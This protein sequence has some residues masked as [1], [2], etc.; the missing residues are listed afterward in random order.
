MQPTGVLDTAKATNPLKDLLKFGQSVWLDYIRRDLISSG[1][2][3]RLIQEDGLRGMTSNPA[4][5]EKAISGSTD[6]ADILDQLKDRS[7]LD[8]KARYEAIAIRDIQDAA[9][10]LRPVYDESSRRDG[11]VSLEVSPYLARDTQGTLEEARRL[12]K[13]VARPNIM[14]K[15]PGTAEGIP[16]FEQLISEGI[17]INVTLLFSQEVYQQVAEAYVRGLTKFAASGGETARVASVASFFISRI[18]NAVDADLSARVKSAKN[19]REEQKLKGLLG[20]V[21]IANGKLA[22]QRYLSIFSG[23]QWDKL[24]EQGGQTQRVLWASTSTKN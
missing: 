6:Y 18:D 9:D 22:Y 21:A 4:I 10:L 8:A 24:R 5:F 17:N 7:D 3:K 13:A 16:A 19:P 1:E 2:L 14:I 20:K 15:V 11:Y 23:A 12:W